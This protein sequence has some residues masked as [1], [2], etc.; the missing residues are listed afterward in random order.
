MQR[1]SSN[2]N[3]SFDTAAIDI[4]S[5][6]RLDD[7]EIGDVEPL[8]EVGRPLLIGEVE[9]ELSSVSRRKFNGNRRVSTLLELLNEFHAAFAVGRYELSVEPEQVR[10]LVNVSGGRVLGVLRF[11][12]PS[13]EIDGL[14]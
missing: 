4:P 11:E 12:F 10:V 3:S 8:S 7:M 9:S 14:I 13:E 6:L 5:D 2:E 1:T